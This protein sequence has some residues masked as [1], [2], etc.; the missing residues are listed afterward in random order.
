MF[1]ASMH[2][3]DKAAVLLLAPAIAHGLP[4]TA[5]SDLPSTASGE[6]AV[7]SRLGQLNVFSAQSF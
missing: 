7:V 6:H 2:G 3:V 1:P 5:I 4:A